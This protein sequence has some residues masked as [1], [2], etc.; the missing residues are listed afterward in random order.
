MDISFNTAGIVLYWSS[1]IVLFLAKLCKDSFIWSVVS[2]L[3][4][5]VIKKKEFHPI[6]VVL[7]HWIWEKKEKENC[8]PGQLYCIFQLL[9]RSTDKGPATQRFEDITAS[10]F[11]KYKWLLISYLWMVSIISLARFWPKMSPSF[12]VLKIELIQKC[13]I[14]LYRCLSEEKVIL[15]S[16]NM[17]LFI[18]NCL[19][20]TLK[21]TLGHGE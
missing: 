10:L 20:L 5:W 8:L 16:W 19:S 17:L 15:Q 7:C 12:S 2:V 18:L 14:S 9:K 6:N 11:L 4:R 1:K 13:F 21:S 3:K